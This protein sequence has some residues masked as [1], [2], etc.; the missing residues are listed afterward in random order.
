MYWYPQA[1]LRLNRLTSGLSFSKKTKHIVKKMYARDGN[2]YLLDICCKCSF[3]KTRHRC[4][5]AKTFKMAA[6]FRP[7]L[8]YRPD[9]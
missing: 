4:K 3:L 8:S 5:N 6:E 2:I 1:L 9:W 7:E